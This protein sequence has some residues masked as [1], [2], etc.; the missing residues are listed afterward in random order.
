[1][2]SRKIDNQEHKNTITAQFT[3]RPKGWTNT[4]KQSMNTI[5]K[6]LDLTGM[7]YFVFG[8]PRNAF[9]SFSERS[10]PF[11]KYYQAWFGV[12]IIQGCVK[13]IDKETQHIDVA[14]L[15]ELAE[16][17]Q[18]AWLKA[19]GMS[20]PVAKFKK[21]NSSNTIDVCGQNRKL[22]EATIESNSDISNQTN[23]LAKLIGMPN[24]KD[25]ADIKEFH[26]ITLNGYF[27]P[28]Y[29]HENDITIFIYVCGSEFITKNKKVFDYFKELKP[30]IHE[31]MKGI[32]LIRVKP[33]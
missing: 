19:M 21:V 11:S 31:M 27:S 18:E 28:W 2:F 32:R 22:I 15:A 26:E 13:W 3:N 4:F 1:M 8:Q 14:G 12:Y 10:N 9:A 5:W 25:M 16:L 29:D 23:K 17:D 7:N 33:E 24:I 30:E 6:P 20:S